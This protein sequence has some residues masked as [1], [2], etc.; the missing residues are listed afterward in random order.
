MDENKLLNL[1]RQSAES[2]DIPEELTPEQIKQKLSAISN[3]VPENTASEE[4]SEIESGKETIEEIS[5]NSTDDSADDFPENPNII[6]ARRIY[7]KWI[8]AAAVIAVAVISGLAGYSLRSGSGNEA[9]LMA[10]NETADEA[11]ESEVSSETV[12]IARADEVFGI[13]SYETVYDKLKSLEEPEEDS[14]ADGFGGFGFGFGRGKNAGATA[15]TAAEESILA[16]SDADS[17][18][19]G[20][21]D[22]SASGYAEYE[23]GES[24]AADYSTTNI[25]EE[26]VDEADIIKTD[27]NYIY[28]LRGN[29][30]R[31]LSAKGADTDNVSSIHLQDYSDSIIEFY[32]DGDCLSVIYAAN[33]V[34]MVTEDDYY[35]EPVTDAYTMIDT[36]DISAPESPVLKG[37][38]KQNGYYNSSRKAGDIIYLFTQYYPDITNKR[39]PERYIPN[40]NDRMMSTEDI[41]I[42]EHV[43]SEDYLVISSIDIRHPDKTVDEKAILSAGSDY[44]VSREN[45]YV[46]Q[47]DWSGFEERTAFMKFHFNN[48]RIKFKNMAAMKG[49]IND[50]FSLNEY[51]GYLRVVMTTYEPENALYIL[52]ENMKVIGTIQNIAQG[53][54][55][56]SA[57]FMGDTGYFVTYRNMDPLFSVDLSDPEHPKLIGSLKVTGFS[58]YLHFYGDNLLLGIGEETNPD[59]GMYQGIKMSMFDISDPANVIEADKYVIEEWWTYCPILNDSRALMIDTDRNLFGFAVQNRYL[60]FSYDTSE[61]F[62]CQFEYE[63]PNSQFDPDYNVYETRSCYVGDNLYL[64]AGDTM[65]VFDM[66]NGYQELASVEMR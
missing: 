8:A 6:S 57:R 18:S 29:N 66:A 60:L 17:V 31:V 32:V 52:D 50:R 4:E 43:R 40:I 37:T 10:Q 45:I 42:P 25:Q 22:E 33:E 12:Q 1:I 46:Y 38:L 54:T 24:E 11:A 48:G 21:W 14:V 3:D 26:G 35:Y 59:S 61:G 49:Y 7:K 55:I 13:D 20:P 5:E 28:V 39:T 51:K 62:I 47:L 27:G 41:C 64:A 58:S 36:Y 2:V 44:Y 16:E 56:Q 19:S 9:S 65:H 63:V 30:I 15:D 53:E 23:T 34:T